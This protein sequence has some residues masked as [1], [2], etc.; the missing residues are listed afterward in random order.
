MWN[1]WCHAGE[2]TEAATAEQQ[3]QRMRKHVYALSSEVA[4]LM[5]E[6]DLLK[7]QLGQQPGPTLPSN[8]QVHGLVVAAFNPEQPKP[9][10]SPRDY[11]LFLLRLKSCLVCSVPVQPPQFTPSGLPRGQ[12]QPA[13][14][15]KGA[16]GAQMLHASAV[17]ARCLLHVA[18]SDMTDCR[19]EGSFH[20]RFLL[21]H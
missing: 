10:T 20:A 6:R 5:R 11:C 3:L 15:A 8:R 4:H 9:E 17:M 13:T 12:P 21:F 18:S 1:E 14:G 2:P 19:F 7:L 16:E